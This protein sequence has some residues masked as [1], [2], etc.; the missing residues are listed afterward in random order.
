MSLLEEVY[1]GRGDLVII[2]TLELVS[3][4]WDETVFLCDGFEDHSL[5]VP[6]LG[7]F[8]PF[9]AASIG[10]EKP[11]HDNRGS[12]TVNF[13]IDNVLGDAQKLIVQAFEQRALTQVRVRTYLSND[14]SQPASNTLT[15]TVKSVQIQGAQVRVT[16]GF[17]DVIARNFNRLTYNSKTSPALMYE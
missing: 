11:S 13:V 16:A 8:K 17:F 5:F 6:E 3:S 12:Q 15:A 14:L 7:A 1:A 10:V 9:T 4:A 2:E